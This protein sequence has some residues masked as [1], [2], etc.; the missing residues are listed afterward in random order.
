MKNWKKFTAL[1]A[2]AL[3]LCLF[4]SCSNSAGEGGSNTTPQE[5]TPTS[6]PAPTPT[7]ETTSTPTPASAATYTI[8]FNANDG[9][10][11][12]ATETQIFMEGT[13]QALKTIAELGFSKNG[14][15]FAGWG[16]IART[17]YVSYA[18]GSS[19]MATGNATLYAL[20]SESPVFRIVISDSIEHG[21][22]RAM[23]TA[24]E[25]GRVQLDT[26]PESGYELAEIAVTDEDGSSCSV[27]GVGYYPYFIM[28]SKD[29]TVTA[30]FRAIS[31]TINV[32]TTGE[33]VVDINPATATMDTIVTVMATPAF[34][35]KLETLTV[36]DSAG[37]PFDVNVTGNSTT[38]TQ[39]A[40]YLCVTA[41]FVSLPPA[42]SGEYKKI[43]TTTIEGTQYD[44]V[45]F[46]LWPQTIKDANVDIYEGQTKTAGA[47]TYC[48]GSDGQWYTKIKEN[49]YADVYK[50]SDGTAVAQGGTSEKWFKVEPIKW[51]ILTE[52]YNGTGKKLLLAEKTLTKCVYYDCY[53][54]SDVRTINGTTIYNN[55]YEHSRVRGFL[56]GLSYPKNV[57]NS[58]QTTACDDFLGAGFL[59]TAFNA[60]ELDI[61][62]ETSVD[63]GARSTLP[64][65]YD[66]LGTS[67]QEYFNN[68]EI[69]YASD[70]PTTDKIFL[71]SEQEVT[72]SEYGFDVWDRDP[73]GGVCNVR[74]RRLTDYAKAMGVFK[75]GEDVPGDY[76]GAMWG[77]R[78]PQYFYSR[79]DKLW[80]V[81][82]TGKHRG[83]YANETRVGVLPALCVKN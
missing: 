25:G 4:V 63:N 47:F 60:A 9:S 83:S 75:G 34:G 71:L 59:Q 58:T 52:N 51:R 53:N 40:K 66:S 28:P 42:A 30:S 69:P 33:G 16:T 70:T 81:N 10:Y 82:S 2:A 5:T 74:I 55:N 27:F 68:G 38:F 37:A 26:S 36:K 21:T 20:W 17:T 80:G 48:R 72:K 19:Y 79:T 6:T 78:S 64:D 41:K 29:V 22:V 18:D 8:T 23:A 39:P 44:I 14:L 62:V 45:S 77:L 76:N 32:I 49:A 57:S 61:I 1:F 67:K 7:P 56:N 50:Y 46:G 12:P 15:Y 65:N 35:W 31:Y 24:C 3:A 73:F 13:T 54:A 43:D 11:N